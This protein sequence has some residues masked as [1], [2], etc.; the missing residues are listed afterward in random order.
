MALDSEETRPLL[1]HD[2]CDA[3]SRDQPDLGDESTGHD[4]VENS[5]EHHT[6]WFMLPG[7]ATGL[8]L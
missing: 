5:V 3:E 6:F 7:L 4:R 2:E 8:V 1:Q